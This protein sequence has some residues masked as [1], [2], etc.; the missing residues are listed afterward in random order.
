M[1]IKSVC[2]CDRCE[3][4][5]ADVTTGYIIK[6][7]IYV[8]DPNERGGLVGNAFPTPNSGGMINVNQIHEY[9][10]CTACLLEVLNI[11]YSNRKNDDVKFP[12][13]DKD[14]CCN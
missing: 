9:C 2:I 8:A 11:R 3:K 1:N 10:F 13:P 5:I 6:G 7:N 14:Y 4:L 12:P